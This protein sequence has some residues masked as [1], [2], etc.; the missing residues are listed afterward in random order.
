M[1]TFS[2]FTFEGFSNRWWAFSRMG[3]RPF[4][5]RMA[6][7]LKFARML[8]TGGGNGFSIF[9]NFGQYG[10]LGV[11]DSEAAAR[12]FFSESELYNSYVCKASAKCTIYAV[13]LMSHGRWD[14]QEVFQGQKPFDPQ[15]PVAVLT[16]A[17]IK[18]KHLLQFW[19]YV[20]RVSKSLE[21]FSAQSI[22]HVGIGEL[23]LV[24]QATFSIWK[25]G[26]EMM[27]YAYK[28]PFHAEVVRKTRELGWYSEELFARFEVQH[29][30]DEGL[31]IGLP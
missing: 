30:E 19:R 22:F 17:T 10:W 7:G 31:G 16:R 9:P 21:D 13:P 1:V 23:P 24:Q 8:G 14:G 26:Q 12:A 28:S 4:R 18:T 11:W 27:D 3:L 25:S 15:K 2:F 5:E 20:P 6:P 29:I